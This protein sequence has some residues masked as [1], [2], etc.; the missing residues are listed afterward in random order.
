MPFNFELNVLIIALH[1]RNINSILQNVV[2]INIRH[3]T[4]LLAYTIMI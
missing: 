4:M 1:K 3:Y 2:F